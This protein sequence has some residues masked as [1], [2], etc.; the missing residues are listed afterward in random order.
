MTVL[1]LENK[2][3]RSTWTTAREHARTVA[4][5]IAADFRASSVSSCVPTSAT[6][7][8]TTDGSPPHRLLS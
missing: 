2:S 8:I 4:A 5:R 1:A 3:S 6:A 7:R